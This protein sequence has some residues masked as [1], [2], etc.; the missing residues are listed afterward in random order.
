MASVRSIV[1]R[2]R[3]IFRRKKPSAP[4]LPTMPGLGNKRPGRVVG[5]RGVATGIP[6]DTDE[7]HEI[8]QPSETEEFVYKERILYVH[9]SNVNSAQYF[10]DQ[11]KLILTFHN[12]G[13]Y[14]YGSVS[15]QEAIN[16]AQAL[17]KGRWSWD[18]LRVRGSRTAHKKPYRRV[19]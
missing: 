5:H 7:D 1:N 17:S 8:L 18:N 9:S 12:G 6:Q 15:E 11:Q 3:G 14:E 2:L 10:I 13:I 4:R 19:K 16:F